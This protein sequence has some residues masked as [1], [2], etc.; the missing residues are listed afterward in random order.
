MT[1][2]RYI[3][4]SRDGATPA[5]GD[6]AIVR[7]DGRLRGERWPAIACKWAQRHAGQHWSH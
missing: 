6:R 7:L 1:A 2:K 3:E 5:C 4:Y